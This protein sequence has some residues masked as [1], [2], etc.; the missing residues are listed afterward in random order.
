MFLKAL[1]S[2]SSLAYSLYDGE[3][4]DIYDTAINDYTGSQFDLLRESLKVQVAEYEKVSNQ[5]EGANIVGYSVISND[6]RVTRY[7]NNKSL[8]I[9]FGVKDIT[10]DNHFIPAESYVIVQERSD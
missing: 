6:V 1:E 4:N 7:N 8:F 9:N 2:G 10:I 5:F 3:F